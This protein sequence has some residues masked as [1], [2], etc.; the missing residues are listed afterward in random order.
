MMKAK[1]ASPNKKSP[2]KKGKID[3]KTGTLYQDGMAISD[4][5]NA[6]SE[7]KHS[8]IEVEAAKALGS[9]R[10]NRVQKRA[11]K[12]SSKLSKKVKLG[13]KARVGRV[14][15]RRRKR[16]RKA[17]N[18]ADKVTTKRFQNTEQG[19]KD[20]YNRLIERDNKR[21]KETAAAKDAD[22]K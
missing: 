4:R 16:S 21:R 3:A 1:K 11:D 14:A 5:P 13:G 2:I 22:K 15:D 12:K 18:K 10:V 20:G 17:S 19:G 9:R 7:F 8:G 6:R